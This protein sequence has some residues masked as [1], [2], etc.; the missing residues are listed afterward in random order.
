MVKSYDV[1]FE[2]V[3]N[4]AGFMLYCFEDDDCIWE[5]FFVNSDDA[6]MIGQR[7]LDGLYIRGFPVD[8][9]V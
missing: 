4:R 2:M 6:H 8:E 5:Q 7:F 3:D 9:F 1:S